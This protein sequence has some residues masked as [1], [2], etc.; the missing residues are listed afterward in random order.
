VYLQKDND[1]YFFEIQA[2]PIGFIKWNRTTKTWD[3]EIL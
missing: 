3:D 1:D 2:F